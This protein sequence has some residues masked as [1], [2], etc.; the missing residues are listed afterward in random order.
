[1]LYCLPARQGDVDM[2]E[3][4]DEV[5]HQYYESR[6]ETAVKALEKR[7]FEAHWF[8]TADRAVRAVLD[9]IPAGSRIGAGGSVTIRE[10]GLLEMLN[11]RGDQ[12]VYHQPDMEK[13]DSMAVRKEAITCP[14]FLS[15]SNA[16]TMEGELV[17]TDG[18][19]NRLAGMI[20]G[21][22]VVVILAGANKLVEDR[23]EAFSRIRNVAAPANARRLGLDVPCVARGRC[24]DCRTQ[25]NICRVTSI[26]SLKPMWTDLKV[27]LVAEPLG[28]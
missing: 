4:I 8:S 16:I 22:E 28:L 18:I 12:L 7:W 24:A 2:P 21:P 3:S 27:F 10:S 20:F 11:E 23:A 15:S 9:L 1:M 17:N 25:L 13:E 5:R 19:G 6:C 26:I 14:Y